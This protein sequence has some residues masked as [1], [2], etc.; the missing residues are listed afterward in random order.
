MVY[1]FKNIAIKE[2]FGLNTLDKD[3]EGEE[4]PLQSF[5]HVAKGQV[6]FSPLKF[7]PVTTMRR[8]Q[9]HKM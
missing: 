1:L 6:H 9:M 4:A 8:T 3:E 2:P 5:S 7:S